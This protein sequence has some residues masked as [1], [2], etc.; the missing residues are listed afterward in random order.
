VS[1]CSPR[2]GP[3]T[4]TAPSCLQVFGTSSHRGPPGLGALLAGSPTADVVLACPVGFEGLGTFAGILRTLAKE[5]PTVRFV[6]RRVPRCDVPDGDGFTRWLDNQWLAMD[7]AVDS[8][9]AQ[10]PRGQE[11]R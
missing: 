7:A 10:A 2:S 3:A 11:T 8:M 4:R 5:P 1:G 9:L 6:T